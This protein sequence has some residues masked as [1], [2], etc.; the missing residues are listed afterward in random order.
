MSC[1][2]NR[3]SLGVWWCIL[4][5]WWC[6]LRVWWCILWV[7][8]LKGCGV[9][10]RVWWHGAPVWK[11]LLIVVT[12]RGG[13]SRDGTALISQG[14]PFIDG[15]YIQL[16]LWFAQKFIWTHLAQNKT[17][18]PKHRW[19]LANTA[20]FPAVCRRVCRPHNLVFLVLVFVGKALYSSPCFIREHIGFQVGLNGSGER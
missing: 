16:Q 11:I 8:R 9:H 18:W 1:A 17:Q 12:P 13:I 2:L 15:N 10:Y 4:G 14:S 6:I 19:L 3:G 7:G 20:A 5:A